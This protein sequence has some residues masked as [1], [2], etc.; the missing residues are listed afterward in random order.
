MPATGTTVG[1][2]EAP[3]SVRLPAA[4]SASPTVKPMGPMVVP[5]VVVRLAMLEIEGAVF[6]TSTIGEFIS[7]WISAGLSARL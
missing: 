1:L 2:L 3:L 6:V 7:N 5:T 4:V